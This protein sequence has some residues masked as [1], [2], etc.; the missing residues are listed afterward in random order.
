MRAVQYRQMAET[1]A[2]E[3]YAA[4]IRLAQRYEA[5]AADRELGDR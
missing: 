3:V 2:P 1:A 4:L 5:M